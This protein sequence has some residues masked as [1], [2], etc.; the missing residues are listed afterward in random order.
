MNDFLSCVVFFTKNLAG[1]YLL[2]VNKRNT[3]ARC[4]LCSKLTIKAPERCHWR[5]SGVVIFNCERISHTVLVLLSLIL[6]MY[7][8]VGL[9]VKTAV[10]LCQ[11]SMKPLIIFTKKLHHSCL[12]G[13]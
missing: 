2:K 11:L 3:R 7:L 13:F 12:A 1:T 6:N 9:P 4:E 5:L 10:G 8:Q